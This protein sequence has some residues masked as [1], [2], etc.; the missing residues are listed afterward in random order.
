[1]TIGAI[2]RGSGYSTAIEANVH[3]GSCTSIAD[4]VALLL[5]ET[6]ERQKENEREQLSLARAEFSVALKDEVEALKSQADATFRGA[7]VQGSL[8]MAGAGMSLWGAGRKLDKTWQ[9]TLGHGLD[10][11]AEPLGKAASKTYAAADA[12]SAEGA[13]TAAKWQLDDARDALRDADSAQDKTLDWLSSMIDRDAA[14]MSAI[15]S[16]KV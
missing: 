11:L 15:L 7:L 8:S 14:T 3:D 10:M 6:Q 16:N 5:L 9:G 13:Q 4:E 1:M 12:K 2:S